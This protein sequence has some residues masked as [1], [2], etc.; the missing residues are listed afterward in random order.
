[1]DPSTGAYTYTPQSGVQGMTLDPK[2]GTY[3]GTDTFE[4]TVTDNHGGTD[5]QYITFNPS[6]T[7]TAPAQPGGQPT[8]TTTVPTNPTVSTTAPA[9]TTPPAATSNAVTIDL[10]A[11]SDTGT[12]DTDNLTNDTTPTI[13]GTTDIPF[14]KVEIL[15]GGKVVAT[16]TSDAQGHYS[17]DTPALTDGAHTLT[18][19]ATGPAETSPTS[20]SGLDLTI[21]TG[22][23]APTLSIDSVTTDDVLNAAEA[24]QAIAIT[25]TVGGDFSTGDTVTLSVNGTD[26]TGTVDAAGKFSIDVPGSDLKADPNTQIDGSVTTTDAAGNT[27][28]ATATHGYAVDTQISASITLDPITPDDV[29]N[30]AEAGGTVQITGTVSGEYSVGDDVLVQVGRTVLH[31]P[32]TQGGRFAIDVQGSDLS[33]NHNVHVGVHATD[34]AGNTTYA[35]ADRPYT[36]D[37]GASVT[38]DTAAVTEDSQ[39]SVTGNVLTN[40]EQGLTLTNTG[41]QQGSYGTLTLNADGSYSYS[42]DQRADTLG[43]TDHPQETFSYEVTDAAGNTAQATLTVDITGTN[44]A[45]VVTAITG[46]ISDGD[47]APSRIMGQAVATD[48]E[49]DRL[50]W[51]LLDANG[52]PLPAQEWCIAWHP[53]RCADDANWKMGLRPKGG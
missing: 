7:V 51:Q 3:S 2:T 41:D 33:G 19:Q 10:A 36:V 30:A 14:S 13:T 15:E 22:A 18:A 53:W 47:Q 21:D 9:A 8:V 16:T 44:D 5:T 46:A 45:P 20:S 42:L 29:I 50:T 48:V 43:A 40:D 1:M 49:G 35:Q 31:T 37:A 11:T 25:G 23:P 39:P 28:T 6:G 12:S 52:Q 38:D 26:F 34:A 4:V 27:A 17:V 32:V 24:G